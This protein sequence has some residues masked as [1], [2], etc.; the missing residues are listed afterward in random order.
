MCGECHRPFHPDRL[1]LGVEQDVIDVLL[2]DSQGAVRYVCCGCRSGV[3]T[4][5]SLGSGQSAFKQLL[6]IVGGLVAEVK[7]LTET[8]GSMRGNGSDN[9]STRQHSQVASVGA[10]ADS[11]NGQSVMGE[12]RELY[13]REKRKCSIILRGVGEV[14]LDEVQTTFS[15]IC[16]I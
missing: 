9:V 6:S 15:S 16:N 13:E 5:R 2:R 8:I 7:E 10:V 14:T 11:L 1:C 3:G 4:D 12:V